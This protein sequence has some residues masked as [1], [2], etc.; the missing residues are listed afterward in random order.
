MIRND[1]SAT[2]NSLWHQVCLFSDIFSIPYK[3][4]TPGMTILCRK[5][6]GDLSLVHIALMLSV[7][8][9]KPAWCA[10]TGSLT[11][12]LCPVLRFSIEDTFSSIE[13]CSSWKWI[14]NI[15]TCICFDACDKRIVVATLYGWSQRSVQELLSAIYARRGGSMT[16]P[17]THSKRV[18]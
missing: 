12:N 8:R 11:S 9:R 4:Y 2:G 3:A 13:S 1:S 14:S 17:A 5:K 7:M 18:K 10:Y 16:I 6:M 15:A